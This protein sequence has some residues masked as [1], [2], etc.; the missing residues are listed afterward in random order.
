MLRYNTQGLGFEIAL[1]IGRLVAGSNVACDVRTQPVWGLAT[2]ALS[3]VLGNVAC[4]GATHLVYRC[5]SSRIQH[6]VGCLASCLLHVVGIDVIGHKLSRFP[7][8][9]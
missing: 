8:N 2:L 1:S 9:W 6:L 3:K 4:D 7:E 5:L